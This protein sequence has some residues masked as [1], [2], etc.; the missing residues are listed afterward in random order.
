MNSAKFS[1]FTVPTIALFLFISPMSFAESLDASDKKWADSSFS[2]VDVNVSKDTYHRSLDS[3]SN[4]NQSIEILYSNNIKAWYQIKSLQKDN[5][6]LKTKLI[7]LQEAVRNIN[8]NLF[9]M[10]QKLEGQTK[11]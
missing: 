10:Q 5:Q 9:Q 6:E 4:L 8:N 2:E 11:Q 7:T 3:L 1:P